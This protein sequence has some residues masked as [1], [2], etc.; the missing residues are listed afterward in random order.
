[1]NWWIRGYL[2]FAAFQGFGIGL[3][4]LLLPPEMQI[5]LRIT[6]LNT[7]FTAA[8]YIAGGVGVLLAALSKRRADARL[9]VVGFGLATFLILILTVVHWPDFMGDPLPHRPVWILDYIV[10]PLGAAILIPLMGLWPPRN[11]QRHAVTPLL[12]V[13]AIVFGA[14]SVL[15]LFFPD[16]AAT[17][18]PWALPPLLG[19]LYGCFVLTFAVGAVLAARETSA[20]AIRDFLFA[21]LT[22]TLLVLVG[23]TLHLERFKVEPIT[24]I[25]FASFGLASVAF[26]VGLLVH[27][28]SARA[29]TA[30]QILVQA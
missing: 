6:P 19:Q 29:E 23:S 13:Q 8:L 5:P 26:A 3:T 20:R 22:L 11:G 18:W 12:V 16:T 17:Y 4:G 30:S 9:F 10:D 2:L 7:R 21:S 14:L 25:W 1:M 24:P 15:L 28:R 27:V